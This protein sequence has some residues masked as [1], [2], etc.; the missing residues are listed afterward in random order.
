MLEKVLLQQPA[1]LETMAGL[2]PTQTAFG[3]RNSCEMVGISLQNLILSAQGPDWVLL[4]IDI[5]NV[6]N[7][8]HRS[9]IAAGL[10]KYAPHLLQW[11]SL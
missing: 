4:Q 6:F 9:A 7:S 8:V 3:G 5:K 11:A 2:R 10:R 1:S